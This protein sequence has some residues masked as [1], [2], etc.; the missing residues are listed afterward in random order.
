LDET[1]APSRRRSL[2]LA[3]QAKTFSLQF[4]IS[5]ATPQFFSIKEKKTFLLG[6]ALGE[7]GG[8]SGVYP[9]TAGLRLGRG[10]IPPTPPFRLALALNADGICILLRKMRRKKK[11]CCPC[12]NPPVRGQRQGTTTRNSLISFD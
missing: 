11:K 3:S 5:R 9:A 4:L 8:G 1:D 6:S 12:P 10:G 7:Q 2:T